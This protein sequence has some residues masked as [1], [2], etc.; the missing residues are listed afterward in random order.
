[1]QS[2]GVALGIAAANGHIKTVEKL[3]EAGATV[4]HQNKVITYNHFI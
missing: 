2:G 3:L 4:K 1:M